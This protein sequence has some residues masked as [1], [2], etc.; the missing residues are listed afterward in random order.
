[1]EQFVEGILFYF[2]WH[3]HLTIHLPFI[4]L[5]SFVPVLYLIQQFI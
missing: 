2:D 4:L 3:I 5:P 1:L